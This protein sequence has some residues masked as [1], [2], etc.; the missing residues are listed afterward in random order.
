MGTQT[1]S[2]KTGIGLIKLLIP[3]KHDPTTVYV[4]GQNKIQVKFF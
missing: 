4:T 1:K 2:T 3:I